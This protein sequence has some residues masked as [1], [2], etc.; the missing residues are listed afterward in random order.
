MPGE[1]MLR[2]Q[3]QEHSMTRSIQ[4]RRQRGVSII[5]TMIASFILLVG[6]SGV[7]GLF[8]YAAGMS[9]DSG[10]VT[11]RAIIYS[12][13]KMEQL[14]S[15]SFTD[16]ATNTTSNT[17]PMPL[18]GGTGI[19]GDMAANTTV[20]GLSTT[21]PTTGYVDYLTFDGVRQTSST[22]AFYVRVWQISI[23]GSHLKTIKV[24]TKALRTT[25][26]KGTAAQM[27]IVCTKS[28]TR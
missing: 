23:N 2:R 17:Y 6:V 7:M 16:A 5:E 21:S 26:S 11:T 20:G 15:L 19:G 3:G 14:M 28:D 1:K 4:Y 10:D 24:L 12:Q 13:D 25:S 9:K 22:G 27:E 8:G 18:T